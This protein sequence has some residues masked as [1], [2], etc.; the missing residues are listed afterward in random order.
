M[1]FLKSFLF[2]VILLSTLNGFTQPF[3]EEIQAFKKQDILK[4]PPDSP[5]LFVGSSSF[6]IWT[7]MDKAFSGYPVINRGFGGSTFPDLIRY[8]QDIIIPYHAKQIVIYC[9]DNDLASSDS[10]SADMV[11]ER[12]RSL[13]EIIRSQQPGAEIAFVSIKPSPS[14]SRLRAKMEEANLLIKTFLSINNHTAF[15]DVYHQ[16]LNPDGSVMTT[17]FREDKLH[18]NAGGYVIWQKTIL[19][20]LIK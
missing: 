10:I 19:P 11:F 4:P 17:I 5:I 9:G 20:Y 16:M 6:R 15:I 1:K 18:M 2:F 3:A 8:A 14:R 12:F 7:D 13:F